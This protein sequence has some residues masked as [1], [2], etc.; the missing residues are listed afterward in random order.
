V[1]YITPVYTMCR[2]GSPAAETYNAM[3]KK[4]SKKKKGDFMGHCS[5]L[6]KYDQYIQCGCCVCCVALA[7]LY[8]QFPYCIYTYTIPGAALLIFCIPGI[9]LCKRT[10]CK[11]THKL[12]A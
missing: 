11:Y 1:Y 9:G 5:W 10:L 3:Q 8:V 7:L 2:T 6:D 4:G 12:I